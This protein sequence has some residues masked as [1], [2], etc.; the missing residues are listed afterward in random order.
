MHLFTNYYTPRTAEWISLPDHKGLNGKNAVSDAVT[1][2]DKNAPGVTFFKVKTEEGI[3][4]DAWMKKPLNFD[5]TKKYPVVFL[6]YS[7]PAGANVKDSYGAA[8]NREYIGSMADDGYIYM[9]V[10]GRGAPAPKGAAWRKSVRISPAGPW[11]EQVSCDTAIRTRPHPARRPS[12]TGSVPGRPFP[13][14]VG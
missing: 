5:S 2:A 7:E 11:G 3:E 12:D 14:L 10:E 13:R 6:V 4:M 8:S 1:H 9:A